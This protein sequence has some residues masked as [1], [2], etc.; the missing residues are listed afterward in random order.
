M[1]TCAATRDDVLFKYKHL[2][3]LAGH[4]RCGCEPPHSATDNNRI[5]DC[6]VVLLSESCYGLRA[7]IRAL[8]SVRTTPG[9]NLQA[10]VREREYKS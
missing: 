9:N 1:S 3:A 8:V 7:Q 2:G 4:L 6:V 5:P 10:T